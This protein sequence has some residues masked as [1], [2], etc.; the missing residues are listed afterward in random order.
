MHQRP[1]YCAGTCGRELLPKGTP[2]P[3]S[4]DQ[5]RHTSRGLCGACWLEAKRT[6]TLADHQPLTR[7]RAEL[8]AEVT[9]A[10]LASGLSR[11][12]VARQ[13]APRLGMTYPAVRRA[14]ERARYV[15]PGAE[16]VAA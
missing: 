9:H 11:A 10:D 2:A 5:V 6:D 12:E 7:T 16:Q 14:L 1:T 15:H 8:L 4:A 3:A 13:M